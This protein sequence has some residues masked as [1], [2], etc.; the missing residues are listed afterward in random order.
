MELSPQQKESLGDLLTHEGWL[1]YQRLLDEVLDEQKDCMRN[2]KNWEEFIKW[3]QRADLIE[4][5]IKT[6]V[7]EELYGD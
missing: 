6:L 5:R 3:N 4:F 7:Q 2:S 1:V